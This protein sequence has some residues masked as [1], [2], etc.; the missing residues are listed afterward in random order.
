MILTVSLNPAVDKTCGIE[1]LE[2]GR[3]N[4]LLEAKSVPGGKGIN[5]TKVLRQFC[6]PVMATGF[7]GGS[8]GQWI[9]EAMERLGV[10]CC[11]T[12]IAESTRTNINVV[13]AD[14][15]VTEILEPGPRIREKELAAFRR[16]FSGCLEQC[17]WVILS[18]SVPEGVPTEIY[19]ELIRE[20]HAYGCKVILDSSGEALRAGV[21]AKPELVKPNQRELEA[22][23]G[24]PLGTR[25]RLEEALW[26][27]CET[28]GG[29][30]VVSCGADGLLYG[31]AAEPGALLRESA[32]KVRAVNTV[33]CGDTVV[34]SLCMSR[35]AQEDVETTLR[36][37]AALAAANAATKE[38]GSIPMEKY[39]ELLGTD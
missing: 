10:T 11:F 25:E 38:N 31:S 36:K 21:L 37:A 29:D 13:A 33:G 28:T 6:M 32:K 27:L 8:G 17:E 1:R 18:G 5:V 19:A 24:G 39:L 22:L 26:R 14:G 20:C 35:I 15:S 4:R 12:K 7:L 9:G 2:P 23:A 34:A 30:V 3:V 16:Q